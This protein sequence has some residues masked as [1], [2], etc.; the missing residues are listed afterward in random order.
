MDVLAERYHQDPISWPYDHDAVA[1]L[2]F[3]NRRAAEG[4]AHDLLASSQ[5]EPL[6]EYGG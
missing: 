4:K 5:G 2:R 1:V 3:L 6:I